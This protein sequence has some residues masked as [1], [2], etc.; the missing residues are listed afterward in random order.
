V[1][2]VHRERSEHLDLR[3]REESEERAPQEV[4]PEWTVFLEVLE[5]PVSRVHPVH[6]V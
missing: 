6:K 5:G 4:H 2:P 1:P 3:A